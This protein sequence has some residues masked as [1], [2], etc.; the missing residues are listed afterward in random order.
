MAGIEFQE[1]ASRLTCEDFARHELQ[2]NRN[3]RARCPFHGGE[4]FNLKFFPDGRCYCH[5]CHRAAD[6]VGLAAATWSTSQLEAARMLNDIFH[7]GVESSEP[8]AEA[9]RHRQQEREEQERAQ[10]EREQR[11]L[12]HCPDFFPASDEYHAALADLG[13]YT[14]SDM[15]TPEGT[16]ALARCVAAKQAYYE[17]W[18]AMTGGDNDVGAI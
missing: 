15:D 6:V 9:A 1:I 18:R 16:A 3:G 10:R 13:R 11:W 2:V 5:V 12:D 4:H 7:L 17:V 14:A 8:D